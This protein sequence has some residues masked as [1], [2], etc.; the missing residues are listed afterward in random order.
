MKTCTPQRISCR[1]VGSICS[2]AILFLS[3]KSMTAQGTPAPVVNGKIVFERGDANGFNP[4]I[5]AMDPDG[6]NQTNLTNN[7]AAARRFGWHGDFGPAWS[8]DGAKIAFA[9]QR[10]PDLLYKHIFVMNADGS[11]QIR[12]TQND[13]N[14]GPFVGPEERGPAWS[15]DGSKIAFASWAMNHLQIYV[16]DADG[17]NPIPLTINST[18]GDVAPAWSPDGSRIVFSRYS[19]PVGG[20]PPCEIYVMNAD[21]SNQVRLTDNPGRMNESPAWSPDGSKIAFDSSRGNN[22]LEIYVMDADGSN[23]IALGGGFGPK[24]SP[25]GA[26]IVF[27]AGWIFVMDADGSNATPLAS[28]RNP[29]WQRLPAPSRQRCR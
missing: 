25:D 10:Y 18:Y 23:Q 12:L 27:N 17:S 28:G 24:W 14:R 9:S 6:S 20:P 11:N 19:A 21:G 16:M 7:P 4:E 3:I 2:L 15:P 1:F 26:K 29:S 13:W 8:P 22:G 5:Y